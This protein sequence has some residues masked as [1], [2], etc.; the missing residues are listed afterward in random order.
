MDAILFWNDCALEANKLSHTYGQDPGTLGPTQS[1]RTLAIIHLA[2]YDAYAAA[3][4]NPANLTAYDSSRPLPANQANT[5][6]EGAI[7]GAAYRTIQALYPQVSARA[8]FNLDAKLN[9]AMTLFPNGNWT[10]G[11]QYGRDVANHRLND[12]AADPNSSDAN[13]VTLPPP[14]TRGA[15]RPDPDNAQGYHGPFYGADSKCFA[16]TK[17]HA[18]D[19]PPQPGTTEYE[20]YLVQVKGK[21]IAPELMGTLSSAYNKRTND[22]TVIGVYWGYDGAKQLGTPPRLY[23]QIIRKVAIAKNNTIAQN[24]RL[25]ALVNVAMGDAG[26]LAW[27]QKYVHNL[28]RPVVGIREHDVSL[29]LDTTPSGNPNNHAD[30]GWLPLGAPKSNEI[31]K[32]FTPPFPAYPSGHATF[33]AAAFQVARLFYGVTGTG[34]D[35]LFNGL[36]FVS[37][38]LNNHST[39]NKGTIRP[40]H[41]RSFPEGLWQMIKENG[42][43][44][45]YLGVHW[46]F[47]AFAL[48]NNNDP[49]LSQNVGGVPLG[50]A[51]AEDIFAAGMKKSAV[52]PA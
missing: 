27:E 21:G 28:W 2:M 47:D 52:L 33:G 9:M 17:R 23:N 13:Y 42:F 32:N 26:I 6:P 22:E 29:G 39:D 20:R 15:H 4:G 16:V 46:A 24:A 51:I 1:S 31:T 40:R 41:Q 43:S 48:D 45:V 34:P 25:F 19:A 8:D 5:W 7:S 50:L 11:F 44:R 49:D 37:E 36:S 38:E 12:R 35:N 10:T 14:V 18:L 30:I 3:V